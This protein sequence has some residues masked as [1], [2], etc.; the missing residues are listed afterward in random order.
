M[1][2][3]QKQAKQ[4]KARAEAANLKGTA[5]ALKLVPK[6]EPETEPAREVGE[7]AML[8]LPKQPTEELSETER[9]RI[10]ANSGATVP[11]V[12]AVAGLVAEEWTVEAGCQVMDVWSSGHKQAAEAMILFVRDFQSGRLDFITLNAVFMAR[13]GTDTSKAFVIAFKGYAK[14]L[15]YTIKDHFKGES[16]PK[17]AEGDWAKAKTNDKAFLTVRIN[18]QGTA[19]ECVIGVRSEAGGSESQPFDEAKSFNKLA[20]LVR[21]YCDGI[22]AKYRNKPQEMAAKFNEVKTSIDSTIAVKLAGYQ[23]M[24]KSIDAQ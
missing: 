13:R 23:E 19:L 1:A 7:A 20:E 15:G 4:H 6:P 5:A 10:M 8:N 17:L 11:A 12:V 3:K 14:D 24:P 18:E 9:L 21:F 22:G 16:A 2:S